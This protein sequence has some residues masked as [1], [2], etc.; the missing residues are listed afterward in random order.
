[1]NDLDLSPSEL[2]AFELPAAIRFWQSNL[3]LI[4]ADAILATYVEEHRR[5]VAAPPSLGGNAGTL[6]FADGAPVRVVTQGGQE[7]L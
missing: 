5:R 1:M 3:H 7:R 4:A 2:P 6:D